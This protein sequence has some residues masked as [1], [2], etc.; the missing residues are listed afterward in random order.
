MK[1]TTVRIPYDL[2]TLLGEMADDPMGEYFRGVDKRVRDAFRDDPEVPDSTPIEV[3]FYGEEAGCLV[4][5]LQHYIWQE[6]DATGPMETNW[7]FVRDCA[8]V[9]GELRVLVEEAS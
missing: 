3:T 8:Y 6:L 5:T 4:A 1:T 2:L 7:T 9:A